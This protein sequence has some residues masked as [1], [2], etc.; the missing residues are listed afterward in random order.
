MRFP[1]SSHMI[2]LPEK[3]ERAL[4]TMRGVLPGLIPTLLAEHSFP[5]DVLEMQNYVILHV[6]DRTVVGPGHARVVNFCYAMLG[7]VIDMAENHG[8]VRYPRP[9][10]AR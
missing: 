8:V 9:L 4:F 6:D 5:N 2:I 3:L 10:E 7:A 1:T